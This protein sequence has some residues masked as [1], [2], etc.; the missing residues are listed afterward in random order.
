[1][2]LIVMG[3]RTLTEGFELLGFETFPEATVDTIEKVLSEL[4]AS[5]EKALVFLEN[6]L[7]YP[8]PPAV[9]RARRL[10][11]RVIITEIPPLNA[12][13]T[14]RPLVEDLVVRVLGASALEMPTST[15]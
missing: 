6:T 1:M 13:D 7:S 4:L 9:L 12:P 3:S 5:K 2:R 14:Y 15:L 11:S 10:A 8:P